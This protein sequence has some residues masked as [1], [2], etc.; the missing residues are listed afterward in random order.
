VDRHRWSR[1]TVWRLIAANESERI[2]QCET[3]GTRLGQQVDM[4]TWQRVGAPHYHY[5]PGYSKRKAGL[6][7]DDYR[8]AHYAG[9]FA[10]A[11]RDGRVG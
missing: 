8:T 5:A 11:Q 2:R 9:D 6:I 10:R 4:R 7:T 1:E 3:C